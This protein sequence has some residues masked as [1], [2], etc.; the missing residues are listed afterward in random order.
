MDINFFKVHHW[1]QH[2]NISQEKES[3]FKSRERQNIDAPTKKVNI[4]L[5]AEFQI[6]TMLSQNN[7]INFLEYWVKIIITLDFLP[8]QEMYCFLSGDGEHTCCKPSLHLKKTGKDFLRKAVCRHWKTTK[9]TRTYGDKI[10]EKESINWLVW[11]LDLLSL[12]PF[13]DSQAKRLRE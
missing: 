2:T 1:T 11:Y 5:T 3:N 13:A 6:I 10:E 9:R 12:E 4:T 8:C 7:R